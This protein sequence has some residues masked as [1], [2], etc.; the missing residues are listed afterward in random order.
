MQSQVKGSADGS[1]ISCISEILFIRVQLYSCQAGK[2]YPCS[3]KDKGSLI[4]NVGKLM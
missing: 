4:G 3:A 1:Y 2:F